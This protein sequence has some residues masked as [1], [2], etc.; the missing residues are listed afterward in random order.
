MTA[1]SQKVASSKHEL[2]SQEI[3]NALFGLQGMRAN[4]WETRVLVLQMAVKIQLS[5]SLIDPQGISNSLYG[6]QRM[7]SDCEDVRML[8]QA[9]AAKIELSWKLLSA[10]HLSNC[11]FGLQGLSSS[12][13]EGTSILFSEYLMYESVQHPP[14]AVPSRLLVSPVTPI[15][16]Y[17]CSARPRPRLSA[18]NPR[19]Q[20]RTVGKANQPRPI[21]SA[22]PIFGTRRGASPLWKN[23]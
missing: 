15:S 8:V 9:L 23:S 6:I 20:R 11:M 19:M 17:L 4:V 5:H 7:T 18:E 13:A 21:W 3:G 2:T 10:Q 22:E 12:E 16:P 1:L 14:E